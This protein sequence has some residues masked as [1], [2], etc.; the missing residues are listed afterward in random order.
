MASVEAGAWPA[1]ALPRSP[2]KSTSDFA[3]LQ[4]MAEMVEAGLGALAEFHRSAGEGFRGIAAKQNDRRA[5]GQRAGHAAGGGFDEAVEQRGVSVAGRGGPKCQV[6]L[7][8][9]AFGLAVIPGV[10]AERG[11]DGVGGHCAG[12]ALFVGSSDR[13]GQQAVGQAEPIMEAPPTFSA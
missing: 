5:S 7:L 8:E 2:A 1:A 4:F 10:A 3:G 6:D 13:D 12:D 11:L 9:Y